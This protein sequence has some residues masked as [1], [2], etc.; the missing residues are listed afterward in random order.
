M[1]DPVIQG[2]L[3]NFT[4]YGFFLLLVGS[5]V[6]WVC[7][8]I[9]GLSG[10]T[11][12]ILLLPLTFGMG[13]NGAMILLI[14]AMGASTVGGS[15]TAILLNVPGAAVNA[16]T[17]FD[18]FP[19]ARQGKAGVAI[20]AAAS[21]S[22]FG[23]I[24]GAFVLIAF[25]PLINRLILAFGPPEFFA[26]CIWGLSVIGAVSGKSMLSGLISGAIGLLISFIGLNPVFGI[27]RYTFGN[28]YFHDGVRL[29][30]MFIGLFAVASAIDLAVTGQAV[31]QRGIVVKGG[32]WEGFI[33]P[34]KHF[35]LFIRSSIIGTIIGAIPG[36]GGVV[37]AFLAYGHAVQSTRKNPHFGKGDIRGVI[38]PESSNNAKDGGALIPTLAF[39]IPGSEATALLLGGFIIHGIKPGPE[40]FQDNMTLIW[41]IIW[42]LIL[43]NIIG[44]LMAIW[45]GP[46]MAKMTIVPPAFISPVILAVS[47]IGSYAFNSDINDVFAALIIGLLGYLAIK[48]EFPRA[49][50][51]IGF[52]LGSITERSFF[53][54]LQIARGSYSTFITRPIA[55][56]LWIIVILTLIFPYIYVA[57]QKKMEKMSIVVQED[58]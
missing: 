19:M 17:C 40:L 37:A 13:L 33:S 42:A 26:M 52:I 57:K 49:P 10:S 55:D 41:V 11:A 1:L 15:I 30:P 22:M 47:L 21:A 35:G 24:F 50:M 14:G 9:P 38:A 4:P 54:S 7:G 25:I 46:K 2:L 39:G 48:Y 31:S 53:Q 32:I 27:P 8:L 34:F 28:L 6:G 44:T 3:L 45:W 43:S 5:F 23:G 51:I 58:D 16:A 20:S 12:I 36:V 18:G 56:V 29:A